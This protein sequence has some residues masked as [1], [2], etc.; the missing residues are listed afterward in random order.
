MVEE[1][2]ARSNPNLTEVEEGVGSN[3][4][5]PGEHFGLVSD[6]DAARHSDL[7]W[8]LPGPLRQDRI[9]RRA[10]FRACGP[11]GDI[12]PLHQV[13]GEYVNPPS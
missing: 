1:K 9:E 5:K 4:N 8:D 11:Y 3:R 2:G 12:E 7:L 13:V 6:P 10:G